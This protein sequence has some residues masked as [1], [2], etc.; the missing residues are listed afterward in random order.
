MWV[1][2]I[3]LFA[4][5]S[6]L[7]WSASLR[8][9]SAGAEK[10]GMEMNLTQSDLDSSKAWKDYKALVEKNKGA[11]SAVELKK[12]RAGSDVKYRQ[13]REFFIGNQPLA[14]DLLDLCRIINSGGVELHTP[15]L[16]RLP[17]PDYESIVKVGFE[18]LKRDIRIVEEFRKAH[19]QDDFIESIRMN[20]P[21][22]VSAIRNNL[23]QLEKARIDRPPK[24]PISSEESI[25]ALTS[26]LQALSDKA[27]QWEVDSRLSAGQGRRDFLLQSELD[28]STHWKNYCGIHWDLGAA[29]AVDSLFE[30]PNQATQIKNDLAKLSDEITAHIRA[31]LSRHEQP[32]AALV[33][34]RPFTIDGGEL[35]P[36]LKLRRG[37]IENKYRSGIERLFQALDRIAQSAESGEFLIEVYE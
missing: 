11:K 28:T 2:W 22:S 36:N 25:E 10:N 4:I 32:A 37:E 14:S 31:R 21:R 5:S 6:I 3:L 34:A 7:T 35:T 13:L 19:L 12:L 15:S 24:K 29:K 20:L 33:V 16:A 23:V 9:S 26:V 1:K 8:K 17:R 30:L 27:D 18:G